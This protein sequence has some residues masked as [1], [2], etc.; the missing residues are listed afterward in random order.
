MASIINASNSS[1]LA[2]T[3]D[4]SGTLNLQSNGTTVVTANSTGATFSNGSLCRAWVNFSGTTIN[5][6]FNVTSVTSPGTGTFTI[7]FTNAFSS[8]NYCPQITSS[9]A[10]GVRE[11]VFGVVYNDSPYAPTTTTL[12]VKFYRADTNAA[13][14]PTFGYVAVFG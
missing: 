6:S 14:N 7:T 5:G 9:F 13:V 12:T 4:L 2:F 10:S 3:S 11:D 1:G 8:A